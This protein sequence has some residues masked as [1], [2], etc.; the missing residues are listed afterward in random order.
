[1]QNDRR[2]S[3]LVGTCVL[4]VE[5]TSARHVDVAAW[6]IGARV[7]AERDEALTNILRRVDVRAAEVI[8]GVCIEETGRHLLVQIDT[9]GL[10]AER[11]EQRGP[12]LGLD[13]E[14][15][16][17]DHCRRRRNSRRGSHCHTRER[18]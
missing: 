8:R 7:Q 16:I 13:G 6:L 3:H 10:H 17:G 12:A 15:G 2:V 4:D 14:A 5:L 1:M 11:V 9:V 18:E